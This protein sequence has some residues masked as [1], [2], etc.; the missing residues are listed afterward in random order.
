MKKFWLFV[1]FCIFCLSCRQEQQVD[2]SLLFDISY[3][4]IIGVS[5]DSG[6]VGGTV[7]NTDSFGTMRCASFQGGTRYHISKTD[8]DN[9]SIVSYHGCY[10]SEE[11]ISAK[12]MEV[13]LSNFRKVYFNSRTS[14]PDSATKWG[15]LS[16]SEKNSDL[17]VIEFYAI[18]D[19]V[20]HL[21]AVSVCGTA[22]DT[23]EMPYAP[24]DRIFS[25]QK[26]LRGG[27]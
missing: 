18:P 3:Q 20:F 24:I 16:V 17:L 9:F 19:D 6:C 26:Y 25:P 7:S 11:R 2:D 13:Y 15:R 4:D 5:I 27:F 14:L 21:Y 10:S 23:V 8:S 12:T 22:R 1:I